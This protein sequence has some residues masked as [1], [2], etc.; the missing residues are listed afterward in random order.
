MPD[1]TY[2]AIDLKSFYASVECVDRGLDPLK[3][4]LLVAD[5]SR[6]DKTICLAV[7]PSLKAWGIPGRARLFEAKQK[8]REVNALR[9]T[10]LPEKCFSGKS[11]FAPELAANSALEVDFI[12]A[13]P[14]MRRYMEVSNRVY[15][16][17]LRYV[18]PEDIH[19]YSV[20][21][22]FLDVTGYLRTYG[23][24][25]RELAGKMIRTVLTETGITATAGIGTNLYLSKVAMDI[26]AKHIQP[27]VYGTRIAELDEKSYRE[28]LWSHRPLTDFWRVGPGYARKLENRGI[29]TMGDIALRASFDEELFYKLFGVNAGLLI[30]HAWGI[31]PCTIADIKA[32]RPES[33]SL[34]VGQVL[35]CPYNWEKGRII[36]K[37]MT[38]QLVLQL[39]EKRLTTDQV[40]LTVGYDV[41]NL[42]NPEIG[43]TGPVVIDR[44]GRAI[45]KHSH[46]SRTLSMRTDSLELII[47]AMIETYDRIVPRELLI[48]RM[49]L[50]LTHTLPGTPEPEDMQ[51]NLFTPPEEQICRKEQQR[52]QLERERRR[53]EAVLDIRRRYGKNAI[54]KG[55]NYLEGATM[56]ERNEQVGG[57]R[58]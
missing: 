45:P 58:A 46:G 43:Y 34:G 39:L 35:Q 41:E 23:M 44:Y 24:T 8:V 53:Q 40:V 30:D 17:Y 31:E 15:E 18:A 22:V 19:I 20:D 55:M 47:T 56:R 10:K 6:T 9:K 2:L 25:A 7:S 26:V 5:S 14:R 33:N 21:E 37:E 38:E 57:H 54:L 3:T 27:D 4:N 49:Y 36:L 50:T 13:T 32:Y 52:Q 16:I 48:R 29:Y 42:D 1:R 12:T 11:V 51:L 28:Q